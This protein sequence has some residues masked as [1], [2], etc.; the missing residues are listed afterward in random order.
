MMCNYKSFTSDSVRLTP[1]KSLGQGKDLSVIGKKKLLFN[2]KL[3]TIPDQDLKGVSLI[4]IV[5]AI[6]QRRP[7]LVLGGT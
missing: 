4:N 5:P 2:S 7:R 1:I 6:N 3:L